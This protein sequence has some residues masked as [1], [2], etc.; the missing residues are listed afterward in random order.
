MRECTE[1]RFLQ[2]V[3]GHE[4]TVLRDE[5][6]FRHLRFRTDNSVI[7]GFDVITWP[8]SLCVDGD[9]GTYVFRRLPDMFQFFR[10]DRRQPK[11]GQALFI[12]LGYWAEKV[13]AADK[14]GKVE[15]FDPELTKRKLIEALREMRGS[16][17]RAER[18]D[19]YDA[20]EACLDA[21]ELETRRELSDH[22]PD[23][24]EWR[25]TD[26]TYH[27]VWCCY[28]IAWGIQ[29]YDARCAAALPTNQGASR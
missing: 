26:Y 22:F 16:A 23:S 14:N 17:T 8:G 3:S 11:A 24:W 2:D 29:Q 21:G 6:L 27:F 13:M 1:A 15:E 4:L 18:R 12:N 9:M 28:A 10:T 7:M 5:G 25:L 19:I 20:V